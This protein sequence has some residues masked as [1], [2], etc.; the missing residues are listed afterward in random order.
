LHWKDQK[1]FEWENH[2]QKRVPAETRMLHVQAPSYVLLNRQHSFYLAD[3]T[4]TFDIHSDKCTTASQFRTGYMIQ[5]YNDSAN[6]PEPNIPEVFKTQL[7][8]F[9]F[10]NIGWSTEFE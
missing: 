10:D 1:L 5:E 6:R 4:P 9:I 8:F 2:Y 7:I 3:K